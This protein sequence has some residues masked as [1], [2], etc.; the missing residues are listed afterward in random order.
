MENSDRSLTELLRRAKDG[1]QT[2]FERLLKQ[3]S[4]LLDKS[5]GEFASS[6][7]NGGYFDDFRQEAC[8]AFYNAVLRFDADQDKVAF[9]YY[10]KECIRNR[11]ISLVRR[12]SKE[13]VPVS[14]DENPTLFSDAVREDPA[15]IVAA[16]DR[17]ERLTAK[18]AGALSPYENRVWHLYLAGR[19]AKE[20]A[21]ALCV[22]EHSV[23]NAVYRIRKKLRAVI[24]N[25]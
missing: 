18:I 7:G 9:G 5:A 20:I 11:L 10:A 8:V 16:E 24:P 15:E 1:D 2:A 21:A 25:P 4:P 13:K 6:I 19:T 14:Y 23:Q 3:Y 17:Y 22:D 12:L